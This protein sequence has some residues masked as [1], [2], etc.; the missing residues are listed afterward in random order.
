[1][2]NLRWLSNLFQRQPLRRFQLFRRRRR[3]GGMLFTLISL[4][5]TAL[6]FAFTRMGQGEN[7][8]Q[9]INPIRRITQVMPQPAAV[10]FS[11]ELSPNEK[12]QQ[13][14]KQNQ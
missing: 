14:N 1:M 10:E 2:N 13:N 6:A 5:A 8:G 3:N 12:N 4:G 9:N 11:A 7:R